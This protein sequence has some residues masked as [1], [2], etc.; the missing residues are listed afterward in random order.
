[1]NSKKIQRIQFINCCTVSISETLNA[2]L[3]VNLLGKMNKDYMEIKGK[4]LR[5]VYE[6]SKNR[7]EAF[8]FT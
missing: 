3:K 7:N 6:L 4:Y 1:M 5:L 8:K 2:M